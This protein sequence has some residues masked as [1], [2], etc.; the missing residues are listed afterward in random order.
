[1]LRVL[2]SRQKNALGCNVLVAC[3]IIRMDGRMDG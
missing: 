3:V 1:M 2:M